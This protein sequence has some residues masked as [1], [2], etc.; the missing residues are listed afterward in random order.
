MERSVHIPIASAEQLEKERESGP[1]YR[2][3]SIRLKDGRC[4]EPAV[5]S[6]GHIIQ[7]KGYRYLPFASEEVESV[8][9]SEKRWNFRRKQE[10]RPKEASASA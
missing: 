10:D 9:L 7:V 8:A 3:V 5:A 6:E 4:F 2:F 1:G